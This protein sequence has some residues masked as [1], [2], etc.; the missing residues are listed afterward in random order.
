M[1]I[2][3]RSLIE[4]LSKVEDPELHRDIVSLGFVK[5]LRA[6]G[7]A[8]FLTLELT[9]PACPLK[10]VIKHRAEEALLGVEGVR[11]AEVRLTSAV[12]SSPNAP[13]GMPGVKNIIAVASGKGGV[14]KT[15]VSVNLALALS[16]LGA[17]VGLMDGDIYGPNIPTMLG[18]SRIEAV[19]NE[20][21]VP[22]R[23]YGIQIMSMG[24]LIPRHEAVIWR[25]PM[26]HEAVRK[27]LKDVIWGNLDYLLIDLPPGTGDVQLSLSQTVPVGG[28]LFVTTPQEV[29][30]QDV[31]RGISM[32]RK[33]E[34]P[35]L[36]IVENMSY[37][38]CGH[39]GQSAEIFGRGG[40]KR[41]ADE[42]GLPFLGEI[43]LDPIVREGGDLGEPVVS[44]NPDSEIARR[45]LHIAG[46]I[47]REFRGN[48]RG[49][50][51]MQ[52]EKIL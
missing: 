12:Q 15:T 10:G 9:T 43:P 41:T 37:F 46:R 28:A 35:I 18:V 25:G 1:A 48:C 8:V 36:G 45:F 49:C 16:R 6:D 14:G 13:A 3:H 33:T 11:K 2:Q 19:E 7:D 4:A 34:V 27:F 22:A 44:A 20:R 23:K 50:G 52:T 32:F 38:I 42:L 39:C 47:D 29:S 51:R 21:I 40:G 30:L 5:D 31:R 26:L 17:S 24:F